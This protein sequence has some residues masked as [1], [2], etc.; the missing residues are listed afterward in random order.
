MQACYVQPGLQ[1]LRSCKTAFDYYDRIMA[2]RGNSIIAPENNN[3]CGLYRKSVSDM[4]SPISKGASIIPAEATMLISYS[5]SVKNTQQPPLLFN[6]GSDVHITPKK[7][8]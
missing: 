3:N 6:T 7:R 2:L 8:F 5:Y 1:A 4:D